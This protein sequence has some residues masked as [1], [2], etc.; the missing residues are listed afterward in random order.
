VTRRGRASAA[1]FL[2]AGPCSTRR[3]AHTSP[4][5]LHQPLSHLPAAEQADPSMTLKPSFVRLAAVAS[6]LLIAGSLVAQDAGGE[7]PSVIQEI[8]AYKNCGTIGYVIVLMS[9][10]AGA[11]I[12]ENFMN[13]KREKLAP[14]DL[15]D[16]IEALFDGENFQEAVELCEQEKNYLTNCVG[17]GLSKLGHAFETMQTSLREMQTEETV[18]LFQKIG[19]LSLLSATAPMMGLFGTVTGMFFTFSAIA[20]AGGS[21]SPA[22]LASGIKMAL[23]TTIFGLTVAIPVGVAF[24]TLRNRVIRVSTEI[25]AISE[26]LFERFRKKS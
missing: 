21:V 14:P 13:I 26:N 1:V 15:L 3:P 8:F 16:E 25:N 6:P 2:R 12:F 7:A 4:P 20:A 22:Q 19:W 10:I 17:A 23:I 24:Y 18:K 5:V 9:V 11:L